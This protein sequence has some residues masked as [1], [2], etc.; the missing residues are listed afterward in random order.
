MLVQ[1]HAFVYFPTRKLRGGLLLANAVNVSSRN[2][3]ILLA[4]L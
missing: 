2:D 4:V 3:L 1:M